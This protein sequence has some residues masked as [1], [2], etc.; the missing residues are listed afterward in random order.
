MH[1]LTHV[2]HTRTQL[3]TQSRNPT[4]TPFAGW[5]GKDADSSPLDGTWRLLFTTAADA[6]FRKTDSQGEADTYQE[7]SAK[8]GHF[9]N[10]VDV[11]FKIRVSDQ[12]RA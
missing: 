12:Q 10:C 7:I 4:P 9:V 2:T 6:T 8:R 3:H 11:R 5:R 1:T